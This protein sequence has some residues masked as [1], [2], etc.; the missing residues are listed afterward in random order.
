MSVEERK[1]KK[2]EQNPSSFILN[3]FIYKVILCLVLLILISCFPI[4]FIPSTQLRRQTYT[5][6]SL[7]SLSFPKGE[8]EKPSLR[9]SRSPSFAR[10]PALSEGEECKGRSCGAKLED[11][12]LGI[13]LLREARDTILPLYPTLL[14]NQ[15]KMASSSG[16]TSF[17]FSPTL[18]SLSLRS[19]GRLR[20]VGVRSKERA[21][22]LLMN[23]CRGG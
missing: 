22:V 16:H 2:E 3:I 9:R 10:G 1:K 21:G 23:E 8:E 18:R 7:H 15:T 19:K 20:S 17:F 5:A 12:I 11:K 14:M 13:L 6:F 4:S